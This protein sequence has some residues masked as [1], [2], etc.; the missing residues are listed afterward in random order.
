M[1]KIA[2]ALVCSTLSGLALAD[3]GNT[4]TLINRNA[5]NTMSVDYQICKA[6]PGANNE[7]FK[8]ECGPV[9]N[10]EINSAKVSP[11]KNYVQITLPKPSY[12]SESVEVSVVKATEKS[13]GQIIAQT[14]FHMSSYGE[15]TCNAD[16]P[17]YAAILDDLN[18]SP[19]IVCTAASL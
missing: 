5:D 1:K 8:F 19:F 13:N 14:Q 7:G 12:D 11:G 4:V 16:A 2:L 15:S 3:N 10:I 17:G 6:G 18:G 9:T